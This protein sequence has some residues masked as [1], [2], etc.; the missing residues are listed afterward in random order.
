[1]RQNVDLLHH[2]LGCEHQVK[3]KG[4]QIYHPSSSVAVKGP[5][6]PTNNRNYY[7]LVGFTERSLSESSYLTNK[8]RSPFTF[9]VTTFILTDEW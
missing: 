6:Y 4:L 9:Q 3:M 7:G 5:T 1:M 8:F 2:L